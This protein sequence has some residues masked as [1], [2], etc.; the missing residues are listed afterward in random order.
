MLDG[1]LSFVKSARYG[2]PD[3]GACLVFFFLWTLKKY[4]TSTF[5]FKK[6]LISDFIYLL[7]SLF[8]KHYYNE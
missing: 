2:K 1:A 8:F 5:I 7:L 6:C 3:K 4:F